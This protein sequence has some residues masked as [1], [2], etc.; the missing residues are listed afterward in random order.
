MGRIGTGELV[1]ILIIALIIVGPAKLPELGRSIGKTLNEFKK[2]SKEF[3][4]DLS[5]EDKP[6]KTEKEEKPVVIAEKSE[7][8][9]AAEKTEETEK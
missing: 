6:Q 9:E 4:D 1:L 8:V 7:S 3:K 5:V 2:V